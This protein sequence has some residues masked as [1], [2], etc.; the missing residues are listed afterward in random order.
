MNAPKQTILTKLNSIVFDAFYSCGYVDVAGSVVRSNMQGVHFQSN[1][2]FQ[3]A[4]KHG[5]APLVV[6]EEVAA[7]LKQDPTFSS[8]EAAA[9]GFV[10]LVLADDFLASYGNVL[11]EGVG[12]VVANETHQIV[13]DY[14]GANVAKPLHVGHLRSAVIGESLKRIARALGHKVISDVHLGDWGLQMGMIIEELRKR[15]PDMPYFADPLPDSFPSESPVTIHDLDELYPA[16]SARAK[17]DPEVMVAARKATVEL[18]EGHA[19]YRALWRHFVTVSVADLKQDYG[20]LGVDF[21]LWLGESDAHETTSKL[22]MTLVKEGFAHESEGALIMSVSREADTKA[23]PPLLLRNSEG[24]VLYG[25][26]DL[27]TIENRVDQLHPDE[28][29][30]VVDKRQQLHLR[31]VFRAARQA[32]IVS[33]GVVLEHVAFGTMNGTDNKPFKTRA[34]GTMKLKDLLATVKQQALERQMEV[35]HLEDASPEEVDTVATLVGIA[36]LKF[37]DLS[38]YHENDYVFDLERF[39][40]FEGYTGP[41]LLYTTVR[42]S[43]LIAKAAAEGVEPGEVLSPQTDSERALIMRLVEFSDAVTN[44][45]ETKSPSV[46]CEYAY[47][48]ATEFSSFYHECPVLTEQNKAR[49]YSHL[50]LVQMVRDTLAQALDLLGIEVPQRM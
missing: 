32:G 42:A 7:Q 34:G 5:K 4:K 47:D 44:A 21:D 11:A 22:L 35:G 1:S 24:A 39:S 48:L 2:A 38:N 40:S 45:W 46:L 3:V 29:V 43:S 27:A 31:Q 23:M 12:V 18:Q 30:Y 13:L 17:V 26:T 15:D 16:A 49:K 28:I 14:G 10:N 33:E 8:V 20:A 41:Y 9:P 6:A 19:G 25:A 37:A 50:Q 36:T